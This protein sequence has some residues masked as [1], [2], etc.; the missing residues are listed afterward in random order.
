MLPACLSVTRWR[1]ALSSKN[2]DLVTLALDET[3][4][5]GIILETDSTTI[6]SRVSRPRPDVNEIQINEQSEYGS[7][8]C[9][10]RGVYLCG[11]C[12]A[13]CPRANLIVS[14][15][16]LV[17]VCESTD[18]DAPS[19]DPFAQPCP[20]HSHHERILESQRAS[21][22]KN[23]A[24]RSLNHH[25]QHF[26]ACVWL[27]VL[28]MLTSLSLHAFFVVPPPLC[29]TRFPQHSH[30]YISKAYNLASKHLP[31]FVVDQSDQRLK[32]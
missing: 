20:N 16:L 26:F 22:T 31:L 6:A 8:L 5:D 25:D 7:F 12:V 23:L 19:F 24:R 13:S 17:S 15:S 9:N 1:S 30:L 21:S 10:R 32:N 27:P 18:A 4:D 28:K 11:I 29:K 14:C 2:L 3:V